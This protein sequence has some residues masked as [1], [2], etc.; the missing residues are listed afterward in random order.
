M[1]KVTVCIRVLI[2]IWQRCEVSEVKADSC[3]KCRLKKKKK[4]T[5]KD[6]CK[7]YNF[8]WWFICR[9]WYF[10]GCG[11]WNSGVCV[12]GDISVEQRWLWW[13]F[14]QCRWCIPVRE[15][16]CMLPFVCAVSLELRLRGL[17]F[18]LPLISIHGCVQ[19]DKAR[20][21]RNLQEVV[22]CGWRQRENQQG[23][24]GIGKDHFSV[25]V[26]FRTP[27]SNGWLILKLR[28]KATYRLS[29]ERHFEHNHKIVHC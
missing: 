23:R 14:S 8:G 20:S 7:K 5:L 21:S 27:S 25:S 12:L 26:S 29:T 9:S 16:L 19:R 3:T 17:L 24:G 18:S 6:L 22:V 10:S 15:R 11:P 2:S 13:V 28:L 4:S 1:L